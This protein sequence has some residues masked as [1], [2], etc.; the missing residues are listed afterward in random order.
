MTNENEERKKSS[1]FHELTHPDRKIVLR[2][3]GGIDKQ[4]LIIVVLLVAFG[5]VMVFSAG[6]V[7]ASKRL[8]DSFY[9]IKRQLIYAAIG[10]LVMILLANIDYALLK[11]FA[12]PIFI[13]SYILLLIVLIPGVGITKNGATR[14]LGIGPVTLQPTEVA[15]FALIL[16]LATYISFCSEKMR[17]F[18]YG[19]LIPA[20]ITV[21]VCVAAMLEHHMSGTI[22]L[23]L[24]G[25]CMIFL[26][27]ANLKWLAAIGGAFAA[28]ALG[29]ILFT[30]YTKN[31]IDAWLHPENDLLGKG[32]QPYQSLLAIGSGGLF[33][34]GLGNSY[35][36][37]LWLP[38]PQN[39]F[40]FAVVCEELGLIGAVALIVL[41]FMLIW[42]GIVISRRAPDTFSSMLCAGLTAKVG[43]QAI[44]NIAVVTASIPTTGIAL[45]FFSY[46]GSALIMQLA[47]MGIIL[48]ISRYVRQREL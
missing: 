31:R 22:I 32:W 37:H 42:R 6:F 34:V 2:T 29:L 26:S 47:E 46:G 45:P 24:I 15:K 16:M 1:F 5:S 28:G 25:A 12:L 30:D 20:L 4:F 23:F 40:I 11:R 27:G 17:S 18:K 41:F 43:I 3:R 21:A 39:D 13:I 14:W 36:K 19:I 9:F 35:Q 10:V 38:E 7:F 33:G 44:L 8:D 48:S